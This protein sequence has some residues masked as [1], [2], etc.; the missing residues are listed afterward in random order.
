MGSLSILRSNFCQ[1]LY[2]AWML[3]KVSGK[4][5]E[6]PRS[7]QDLLKKYLI[8]CFSLFEHV[9]VL[10]IGLPIVLPIVLPIALLIELP[11]EFRG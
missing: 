7:P 4:V 9:F 1:K 6:G 3:Q 8:S 2:F 10:P 11:I 5:Q